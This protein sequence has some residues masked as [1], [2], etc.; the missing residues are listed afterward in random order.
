MNDRT[1]RSIS[2]FPGTC[3]PGGNESNPPL[4]PGSDGDGVEGVGDEVD[5]AEALVDGG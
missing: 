5:R 2:R 3:S 4:G 1:A